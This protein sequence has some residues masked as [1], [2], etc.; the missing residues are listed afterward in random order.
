MRRNN[1]KLKLMTKR[2]N[3]KSFSFHPNEILIAVYST[4]HATSNVKGS[5]LLIAGRA[6][7]RSKA[8]TS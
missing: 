3:N 2:A 4:K 1:R 8:V 6:N 5:K 7:T